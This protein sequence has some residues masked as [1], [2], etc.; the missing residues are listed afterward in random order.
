[1]SSET[2]YGQPL[3][4][5]MLQI[6]ATWSITTRLNRR[7]WKMRQYHWNA[8]SR[9]KTRPRMRVKRSLFYWTLTAE[10]CLRTTSLS[11]SKTW[12]NSA[13]WR[14]MNQRKTNSL[15]ASIKLKILPNLAQK[16]LLRKT[17]AMPC[18]SCFS[19]PKAKLLSWPN[20]W[21]TVSSN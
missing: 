13:Y 1:M 4:M 15:S 10:I 5:K 19:Q 21:R 7:L 11:S 16:R 18:I 2:E 6:S 8:Y 9:R 3:K 17:I 20:W 14:L 12:Q